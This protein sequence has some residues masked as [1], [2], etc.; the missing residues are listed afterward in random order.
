MNTMETLIAERDALLE[1]HE[2][3]VATQAQ[4]WLHFMEQAKT[5]LDK[6]EDDR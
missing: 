2:G 4:V 6:Q 5:V 3:N 1:K